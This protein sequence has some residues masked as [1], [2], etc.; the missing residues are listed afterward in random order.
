[1]NPIPES[2]QPDSNTFAGYF[3]KE[4]QHKHGYSFACE[5][6]LWGVPDD[7]WD[8]CFLW[9]LGRETGLISR[10]IPDGWGRHHPRLAQ[11][12]PWLALSD[13]DKQVARNVIL[14]FLAEKWRFWI[15]SPLAI[16][17]T[18][19]GRSLSRDDLGRMAPD[20][21]TER[22]D[23]LH[24]TIPALLKID[25]T[26]PKDE[27]MRAFGQWIDGI[28]QGARG[29][30]AKASV[31]RW[32]KATIEAGF[33]N[34]REVLRDELTAFLPELAQ[35]TELRA[36]AIDLIETGDYPRQ[37]DEL[38]TAVH[39][40]IDATPESTFF[41]MRPSERQRGSKNARIR[42]AGLVAMR[43]MHFL[44]DR[45]LKFEDKS[46]LDE[47][48]KH[49]AEPLEKLIGGLNRDLLQKRRTTFIE[50]CH[51]TTGLHPEEYLHGKLFKDN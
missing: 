15:P 7:E 10:H 28:Q 2:M 41:T 18:V 38:E 51:H 12:F 47:I 16:Y 49:Y 39:A 21:L 46:I 6:A 9:E 19:A 8:D 48:C 32:L 29:R 25:I 50:F 20:L 23:V 36:Y 24:P 22:T 1:M 31:S 42:K 45:Q 34:V 30:Q 44:R 35:T 5:I 3:L 17:S 11:A 37:F 13:H 43:L 26:A 40:V 14:P 4:F 27:L 33:S